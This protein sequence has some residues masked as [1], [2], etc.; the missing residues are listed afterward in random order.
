M[1]WVKGAM[2]ALEKGYL[3]D[4]IFIV[5]LNES[6]DEV[7]EMYK[8]TFGPKGTISLHMK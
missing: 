2:D 6:Q 7:Y 1:E 8:F 5:Y 4:L 3:K